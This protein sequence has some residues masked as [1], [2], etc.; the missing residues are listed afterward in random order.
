[1]K[2]KGYLSKLFVTSIIALVFLC[3]GFIVTPAAAHDDDPGGLLRFFRVFFSHL[4]MRDLG[5]YEWT[6][7]N[8]AAPWAPRTGLE[9]VELGG[10]FYVM[11]GRTPLPPPAPPFASIIQRD[12]WVSEDRGASWEL[13]GE[14]PWPERAFFEAVTKG[15]YM[16]VM[17]GQSFS[18]ECPIPGCAPEDQVP[19]S[20]FYNDVYRS[21]DGISWE[22]MTDDAAWAPRSGLSAVVHRGWIYVF[23][24]A[25]GDD[26]AIGGAGREFFT[27]VHKS[28]DGR[29]WIKVTDD[30]PWP[31][32][33]GAAA[34]V[35]NG[36]IYLL[37]GEEGFLLEPFG[38]VW[39][40]RKGAEWELINKEAWL[41]RSGHKCGVLTGMIVCFGGFNL[42]GNPMD[43]QISRDGRNWI[44]LDPAGPAAPPWMAASPDAIKYDFDIIVTKSRNPK[45]RG[46]HTFGGDRET[47]DPPQGP[48]NEEDFDLGVD[49][50]VWRFAPP[51]RR[52][53]W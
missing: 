1:M 26:E 46:I 8:P 13:L 33:G 17:G 15:R 7:V 49:N 14:A 23:G 52:H 40:S 50:D 25:F 19:V 45:Y 51:T 34:V 44:G 9:S 36:W 5:N 53:H 6:E 42:L 22:L 39:R 2:K 29:H 47:F 37:G 48:F 4:V 21:S 32:R 28:R 10:R 16:Y 3:F 30:V 35:K 12:V 38:D 43:V 11:G 31:G 41:P 18:L 20:V 27:D 24:G